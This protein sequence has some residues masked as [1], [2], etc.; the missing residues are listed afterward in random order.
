M[1]WSRDQRKT[2]R[3]WS[4]LEEKPWR[5]EKLCLCGNLEEVSSTLLYPSQ[6]TNWRNYGSEQPF[7]E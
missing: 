2:L 4:S 6:Q 3:K 1:C 7:A 5:F